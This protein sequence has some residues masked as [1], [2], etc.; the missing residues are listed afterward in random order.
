MQNNQPVLFIEINDTEYIFV[1]GSKDEKENFSLIY[2]K[3]I[4]QEGISNKR[5][6]NLNLVTKI[7]KENIYFIEKKID[8]IFKEVILIIDNFNCSMINLTGYKKLNGSQLGKDNVTYILNDLKTKLLE[9][10]KNKSIIHIFN[11]N[12]LLDKKKINNLPIGLFGNFYSHELSFFLID[13]NDYKNLQ[14]IFEKCNLRIKKI[15]S[16]K[17]ILG[18]NIINDIDKLE[19]F[20]SV[21]VNEESI[22]IIFFE[23]SSF[24]FSQKFNF[25]TNLILND[26]SKVIALKNQIVKKIL[27]KSNF[28]KDE[29]NSSFIERE[30]FIDQNFRKIKK[31]LIFEIAEAR[32]Q[33]IAEITI[34]KNIN[35]KSFLK[36]HPKICLKINDFST[37]KSFE[38]IYKNI[39]SNNNSYD[40]NFVKDFKM[41]ETYE[42][43]FN[44]VQYGW[45]KE[46]IPIIHEKKS[47]ISRFFG[48]FFN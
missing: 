32:I 45:K 28:S 22:D 24:R 46:A 34:Y 48:F 4:P 40:F 21:E 35:L 29:N 10:E 14:N 6:D 9:I 36:M 11:S 31:E 17:F 38:N 7:I 47:F 26:I 12:Y 37:Q 30:F 13:S 15:I 3:S 25:G 1:V 2:S 43:A 27:I 20:L 44:L 16:K 33:E 19:T 41:E 18:T 23:N 42:N 5:I 8:F 39:F